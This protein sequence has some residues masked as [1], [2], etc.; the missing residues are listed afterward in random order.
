MLYINSTISIPSTELRFR[1]SRSP[2]PG[3]QNVN[4][5][6]SKATLHWSI[7]KS[8]SVSSAIKYRL[9]TRF[10]SRI[11]SSDEVVLSSHQHRDQPRNVSECLNKL[12]RMI[13]SCA[14]APKIRKKT[15]P[16]R[17]SNKRR[18]ENKKRNSDKKKSRSK[19]DWS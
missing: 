12:K 2:G 1:F 14:A 11:N 18:L 13:L 8:Q 9:R 19:S 7:S 3:G 10:P 15:K 17:A 4:K 5:V 6:N 16:S